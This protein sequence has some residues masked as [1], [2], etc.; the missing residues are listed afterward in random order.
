IAARAA[1]PVRAVTRDPLAWAGIVNDALRALIALVAFAW[2]AALTVRH[3]LR[4]ATYD[5]RQRRLRARYGVRAD[6]PVRPYGAE[7]AAALAAAAPARARWAETSGSSA[8]PKRIPYS[9]E[10]LRR[11][12]RAYVDS[13]ARGYWSLPIGR[14]SLFV[15]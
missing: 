12:R 1:T 6:M 10:R 7:V 8:A 14:T 2:G 11:V 9:E 13:F 3:R 5:L 4:L 15:M